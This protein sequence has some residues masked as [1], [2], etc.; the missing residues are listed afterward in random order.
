M[1]RLAQVVVRYRYPVIGV[2]I[3][4]AVLAAPQALRVGE[5]LT[6][7]L[8]AATLNESARARQI[9]DTRFDAAAAKVLAV[10]VECESAGAA[11]P[12]A[13]SLRSRIATED[14]VSDVAEAGSLF[15]TTIADGM[16]VLMVFPRPEFA[17]RL[18]SRAPLLRAELRTHL[19]APRWSGCSALLT[20]E[21][22]MESDIQEIAVADARRLE[23]IALVPA[24]VILVWAF[25]S[26]GAAAIPIVTGVLA[27]GFAL[28]GLSVIAQHTSLAVYVLQVVSMIGLGAGIDYS[29][30]ITSRFREALRAGRDSESAANLAGATA[31]RTVLVSGLC[32]VFGFGALSLTPTSEVRSVGLAGLI[33]VAV[34]VLLSVTLVPALLAAVGSWLD[35]PLWL[36]RRLGAWRGRGVWER[37]GTAIVRR[38]WWALSGGILAVAVLASPLVLLQI[39][40]PRGGWYPPEAESS[41]AAELL[42]VSG[43]GG[44]LLPVEVLVVPA[45]GDR[46]VTM[47]RLTALKR[48]TDSLAA[49]PRVARVR[50]PLS[51]RKGMSMLGYAALYGDM[52]GARERYP[53]LFG[54]YLSDD[55]AV[56]RLQVVLQDS[57]SLS[58]GMRLV[59][60]VR[61]I[62]ESEGHGLGDAAV[63][64]GGFAA[65]QVDEEAALRSAFPVMVALILGAT[66]LML[67]VTLRSLLM[68]I[69]AILLNALSVAGGFGLL[70]LVFQLGIGGTLVGL[71]AP[72]DALFVHVLVMVFAISFGMSMDYEIF[73]IARIREAFKRTGDDARATVDGL[74]ATA[75]V[76]TNAAAIMVVVFGAF[77]FSRITMARLLG[78]GLAVTILIDAT[79]VRLVIVPAFMRIAGRWN[80]WPGMRDVKRER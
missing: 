56:G 22:V 24:A 74:S 8:P 57:V 9:L 67:A 50:G 37:W 68:P 55:G 30:L 64:V 14:F 32:V 65:A 63:L 13:E 39:G 2:W 69:K 31:G 59:R 16:A 5:R 58:T 26:V 70:V 66:G 60:D 19:A 61:S 25:G 7:D 41:R 46:A 40:V 11:G 35:R 73:L 53:E 23:R 18:T 77:A 38:R 62:T 44:E 47:R 12:L 10:V 33:V 21:P 20:G 79:V 1:R 6:L 3:A 51:L 71:D 78:F 45:E 15:G 17:D 36:S 29:L 75:G 80:W 49:D 43:I 42:K 28:G 52:D 27:I 54:T 72:L 34:A 4:L 48:F 76:I